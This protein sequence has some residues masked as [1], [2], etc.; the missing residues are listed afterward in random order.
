MEVESIPSANEEPSTPRQVTEARQPEGLVRFS[1]RPRR[2]GA[3]AGGTSASAQTFQLG[4]SLLE[5]D[6]DIMSDEEADAQH[7][8]RINF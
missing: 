5:A 3:Q 2:G 8:V 6:M 7:A 4:R 1:A